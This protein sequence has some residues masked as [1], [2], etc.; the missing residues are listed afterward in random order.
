MPQWLKRAISAGQLLEHFALARTVPPVLE[1][2]S[3][4]RE[5]IGAKT[6]LKAADWQPQR[7]RIA[8]LESLTGGRQAIQ[9]PA[10]ICIDFD[11][12]RHQ[13]PDVVAVADD[14]PR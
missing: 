8:I 10:V 4:L 1:T 6:C 14:G 2:P 9:S 3:L 7:R 12:S 5:Q 13:P 11:L